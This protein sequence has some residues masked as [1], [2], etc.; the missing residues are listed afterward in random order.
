VGAEEGGW[1]S[2]RQMSEAIENGEVE[3]WTTPLGKWFPR[4]EMM[5]KALEI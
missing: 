5:A 1:A 4:A 3:L 2:L